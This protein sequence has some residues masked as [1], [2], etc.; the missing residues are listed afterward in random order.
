MNERVVVEQPVKWYI[1]ESGG[2]FKQYKDGRLEG[3]NKGTSKYHTL[4][5]EFPRDTSRLW[6]SVIGERVTPT[7]II[8]LLTQNLNDTPRSAS[9]FFWRKQTDEG[10]YIAKAKEGLAEFIAET[11]EN[12]YLVD[13]NSKHRLKFRCP[14]IGK[15]DKGQGR[16]GDCDEDDA[17]FNKY[18]ISWTDYPLMDIGPILIHVD[19]DGDQ[20]RWICPRCSKENSKKYREIGR[21]SCRERV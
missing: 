18:G 16:L 10:Y 8:S 3:Q 15:S 13:E 4:C 21:A 7:Q 6:R 2:S 20:A 5:V 19:P 12:Y 17:D 9:T 11:R 1:N 14:K